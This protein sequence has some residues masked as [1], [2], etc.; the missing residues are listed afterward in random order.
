M[1]LERQWGTIS[2]TIVTNP[3]WISVIWLWSWNSG[4]GY[5]RMYVR[6]CNS[7]RKRILVD[8]CRGMVRPSGYYDTLRSRLL[9]ISHHSKQAGHTGDVIC[10]APTG[11]LDIS[12]RCHWAVTKKL[13]LSL[14]MKKQVWVSQGIQVNEIVSIDGISNVRCEGSNR[15]TYSHNQW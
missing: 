10:I 12:F 3:F 13:D 15:R 14:S 5:L 8:M 1:H 6:S 9:N 4:N 7:D 2:I 11:I